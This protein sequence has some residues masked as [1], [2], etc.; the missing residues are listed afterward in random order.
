MICMSE[1]PNIADSGKPKYD[2]GESVSFKS[3]LEP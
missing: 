2:L 1:I 3:L